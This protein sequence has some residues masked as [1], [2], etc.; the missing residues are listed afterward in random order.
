MNPYAAVNKVTVDESP[1]DNL[2][3]D[4]AASEGSSECSA[5][6]S[7]R[8]IQLACGSV[9]VEMSEIIG[10]EDEEPSSHSPSRN[11]SLTRL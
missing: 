11:Q 7:D 2:Q 4:N 1:Y 9:E 8:E 10:A 6:D 3:R 5:L